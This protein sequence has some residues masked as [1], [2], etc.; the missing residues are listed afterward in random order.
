MS[1]NKVSIFLLIF[2]LIF[3]IADIGTTI[4]AL[5]NDYSEGNPLTRNILNKGG[6]IFWIIIFDFAAYHAGVFVH[7]S[8][9]VNR[10]SRTFFDKTLFEEIFLYFW[11]RGLFE[12][13]CA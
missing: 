13:G 10:G 11:E 2:L 6:Y 1:L 12:F 7:L 5:N 8:Q 3:V 4:Y 9:N